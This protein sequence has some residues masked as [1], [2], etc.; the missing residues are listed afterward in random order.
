MSDRMPPSPPRPPKFPGSGRPESPN[1][2]VWVMV[3][4]IVGVLA[5]GFFTPE[6]FGLGPRKENLESFEAQYKAGRVVLNDPKAPVEVVL[7]ENGSEGVIHA[8]V[9]RKE[10]Q[11]KVEMTP[12]ALTYSMSLPDRDKPLLNELSGYRVVE[13]PYRTEEG[14]N[15]SLIPEGAQ[16]LSVPEFNRLALEG[17][18]AGG[19]DGIILAEDGNQNVLVG[20]IVTR[21]WPAATGDASVDKQ[22]FER[23]EVP[24]TLEFQGDR[25]KQ[26]L[27][28][29]TKFK[30]E[31][32]SWGGI[33]LNLLPIVLILVILFFM[34]RAQS[35]GARGAMSFG[36]SR[37]RLISPDKNK[38]TFKDVAGISEAK[39]EVWELVEFLRNPEKFRDL[40]ATIP[41]GVLMVGAPGTGKTLLA[42]A[43]A[44]ESNASFYSI[45]GSDFVEMF[46]GVG[47]SRVRD[48]FEQAKRTAPSLIFIDEIDAVGRQRGY[49]MGGGNDE[50]EQTLNALL[51]EMDGFENNSNVIVIAA[52]N[53]ADILDPALLRPGRF[54]RRITVDRPN[55][56]GRLATLQV[57]TRNIRLA[58]DVNLDKIAQATA[59]CVGADLANLVNEAALRAVRKGRKA[60]NQND[61]LAAFETVIAGSEK[62]G[63][64]ITQEEKRIIAY[65]EVGHALVAA[66]QKNAQPVSKITIVPHTQGALGYTLHLPE[67]EKFLMSKEDILAEIRTLLAGRSSEEIVCNTMTSGAA[68]DIERATEMARNL[69]AR[70]GMCDE[71]DMMALG[72]VQSQYLDGGYSMTCAQET[73]A[74]AD[75]ATIAII[76][77][78][79]QDA[80]QILSENRELL[81]KIAV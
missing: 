34:F 51:V 33:L 77:Q 42:R 65:H 79:H 61:L 30:R 60:V 26:L 9:Y 8:L 52:T 58:E 1:W 36:K 12:F 20:Q 43:I 73:Y 14:K 2:G 76:R 29:D 38:V 27:G 22:R 54:D 80:K 55:L 68:N 62:K 41:R 35:G 32:G 53:R 78:C 13:S 28:P 10:I 5:F 15:V 46:V 16:K 17:R 7:S 37:A 4:L 48:M 31:S 45:S 49:G 72:T 19:K 56:A 18:I 23:V 39:E 25:V 24:F 57:H 75:R 67:E 47:A 66:K 11:P 63:T 40:G 44:G 74:A 50:R 71:F 3:L 21:I 6:S 81:D 59:G 64:V 69:V 70:F